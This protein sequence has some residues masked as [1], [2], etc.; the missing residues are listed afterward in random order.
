MQLTLLVFRSNVARVVGSLQQRF[1]EEVDDIRGR[2]QTS[3][4]S[5]RGLSAQKPS[6]KHH[7]KPG[8]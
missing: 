5:D 3:A 1:E 2:C 7:G 4:W 6:G 8:G